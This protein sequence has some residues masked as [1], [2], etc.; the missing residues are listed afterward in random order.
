MHRRHLLNFLGMGNNRVS[1]SVTTI[2]EIRQGGSHWAALLPCQQAAK[3]REGP[4]VIFMGRLTSDPNDIR[5]F[6]RAIGMAYRAGRDD[7]SPA[8]IELRSWKE[9]WSR[10][11]RVHDAEFVAGTMENGVSLNELMDSLNA[12]SFASTQRNATRGKGNTNPRHAYRQQAAVE[13][14]AEGFFWV[15]PTAS[16]CI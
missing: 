10:Y 4:R 14:S 9:Q 15:K 6:G 16:G 11:I 12:D 8:D 3:G 2:E 5:V 1:L 7:A 13:L